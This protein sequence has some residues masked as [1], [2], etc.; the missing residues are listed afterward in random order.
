MSKKRQNSDSVT[1]D[2]NDDDNLKLTDFMPVEPPMSTA[3]TPDEI[4]WIANKNSYYPFSQATGADVVEFR[5]HGTVMDPYLEGGAN[6]FSHGISIDLSDEDV[7]LI[8]SY[9]HKIPNYT[10][11]RLYRWP[12]EANAVKFTSKDNVAKPFLDIWEIDD[13]KLIR[14]ENLRAPISWTKVKKGIPVWVEYSIKGYNGKKA[15]QDNDKEF[16]PGVTLTLLSIGMLKGACGDSYD[17]GSLKKKRRVGE[18]N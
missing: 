14:N 11:G 7:A 8:K 12:I 6:S 17:F 13:A 5:V 15:T 2:K 3:P 4:Q 16:G 10:P 1:K 9:V 18:K